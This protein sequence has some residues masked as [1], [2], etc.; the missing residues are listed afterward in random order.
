MS[1]LEF[2]EALATQTTTEAQFN[3]LLAQQP[4]QVA[5]LFSK[6]DNEVI[7]SEALEAAGFSDVCLVSRVQ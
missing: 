2:I 5:A 3:A 6:N 1:T 7:R 4:K